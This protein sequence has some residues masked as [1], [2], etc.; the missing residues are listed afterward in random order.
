MLDDR[1]CFYPVLGMMGAGET[2][3]DTRDLTIWQ[4]GDRPHRFNCHNT[5]D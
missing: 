2:S 4:I 5:F 1:P 3:S